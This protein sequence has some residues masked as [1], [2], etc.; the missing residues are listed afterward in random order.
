MK[1]ENNSDRIREIGRKKRSSKNKKAHDLSK[2]LKA[3]R[4]KAQ[5]G[6]R[7]AMQ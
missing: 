6:I 4:H 1:S 5:H 2:E 7:N 3:G